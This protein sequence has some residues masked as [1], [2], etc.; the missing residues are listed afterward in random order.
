LTGASR[1]GLRVLIV[2]AGASGTL[3]AIHL[4]R[5]GVPVELTLLDRRAAFGR[6]LAYGTEAREHVLN[7]PVARMSALPDD[8]QDL[9]VWTQEQGLGSDA[10]TFLPRREYGRYLSARLEQAASSAP[11]GAR[12]AR[13]SDEAVGLAQRGRGLALS[14]AS[15]GTLEGD[16]VVLALGNLA[17]A[18]P[19]AA[20]GGERLDAARYA[21]DAWL[22]GALEGI[23]PSDE[24]LVLGTGLTSVD[25]LLSLRRL[26]HRGR[27][28][29]LSRRGLQPQRQRSASG[30]YG[31]GYDPAP[32]LAAAGDL[33]RLLRLARSEAHARLA[34]GGDWR[35]VIAALR[36]ITPRL[37]ASLGARDRVRFLRHL[38]PFWDTHRHRM[39]PAVEDVLATL[40]AD[41]A[42][43][44]VAGRV[45][46][47]E[48]TPTGTRVRWQPRG[49][50][51]QQSLEVG[52]VINAT[53]ASLDLARCTDPLVR[54]LVSEGWITPDP[55]GLGL[56][57]GPDGSVVNA[58]GAG[59]GRMWALGGLRTG[60]LWESTAV[61]ELRVQARDLARTFAC[62]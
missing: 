6:G 36:P 31:G 14:L 60:S 53:G 46:S 49:S 27:V 54:S 2:G 59:A 61:P 15:G 23:Q 17:P 34:T 13:V 32:F 25:V 24:V 26:R 45:R 51:E 39:A 22:P 38:R 12:L 19:L 35:D 21:R 9:L 41:G 40:W 11:A 44:L 20:C 33:R 58:T 28:W 18:D 30:S 43:R 5:A 4:L 7:V 50:S 10:D 62:G 42:F 47:V 1:A 29:A 16:H 55:L 8:P 56:L 57:T 37:W 48:P 3:T 52:R